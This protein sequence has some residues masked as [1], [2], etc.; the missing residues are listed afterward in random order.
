MGEGQCW[1]N[2]PWKALIASSPENIN[3][4]P[5]VQGDYNTEDLEDTD[6]SSEG[7]MTNFEDYRAQTEEE[8]EHLS[9]SKKGKNVDKTPITSVFNTLNPLS[10]PH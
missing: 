1:K 6:V 8:H 3:N 9:S 4:S 5:Q 10:K 7:P 2:E